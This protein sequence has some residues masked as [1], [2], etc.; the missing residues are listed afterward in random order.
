[1]NLLAT[2]PI[3]L[4]VAVGTI[5]SPGA[6][7]CLAGG[8]ASPG[9]G[10]APMSNPKEQAGDSGKPGKIRTWWHPLLASF[11]RWLLSPHYLLQEE[12]P[13]GQK[14]LQIDVLL[15]RKDQGELSDNARRLLAGIVELLN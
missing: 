10:W 1:M 5:Q 12:V 9:R 3:P 13:V 6:A 2:R 4:P 14:P 15:L 7:G 11:L 8:E